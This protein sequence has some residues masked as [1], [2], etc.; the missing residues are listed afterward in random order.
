MFKVVQ[1]HPHLIKFHIVTR[2]N[3]FF[4]QSDLFM[5]SKDSLSVYTTASTLKH[6]FIFSK[7]YYK[8][9]LVIHEMFKVGTFPKNLIK[10][11]IETRFNVFFTL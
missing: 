8:G 11:H 3:V 9:L 4:V 1:F 7:L 2:F 5:F 6:T 10:F